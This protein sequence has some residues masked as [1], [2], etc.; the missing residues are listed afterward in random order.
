MRS[1]RGRLAAVAALVILLAAMI[2]LG[3]RP[4]GAL[5]CVGDCTGKGSVA[6]TDLVLGVNIA[7]GLVP[8][9]QCESFD[10]NADGMVSINELVIAVNNALTG[11]CVAP[12]AIVTATPSL[13]STTATP[14]PST[15]TTT[16]TPPST[17]T[18]TATSVPRFKD[19]G[20]GTITDPQTGLMWEKK[21]D[22][23][24][25]NLHDANSNYSWADVCSQATTVLCQPT[26][27]AAA[28]CSNG[29]EGGDHSGCATCGPGQGTCTPLKNPGALTTIWDWLDQLNAAGFAGHND[30]RLPTEAEL[31]SIVDFATATP[32]AVDQAFHGARCGP[33]CADA[34]SAAC[35]C[36]QSSDY[37]SASTY[38]IGEAWS[39]F[40]S[41]PVS[42]GTV[43]NLATINGMLTSSSASVRAV[44]AG[45]APMP[46]YLDNGDGTVTDQLTK[47]TWEKKVQLDLHPDPAN[48][49]DA[50]DTYV[51]A[52]VCTTNAT[53]FCQPTADASAACTADVGGN[54]PSCAQC[55][56]A[57]GSC[58]VT[59]TV[60]TWVAA[61][62]AASFAGHADWRVPTIHELQSILEYAHTQPAV[63]AV[64]H[65]SS[66]G[67][68]CTDVSNPACSCT[69]PAY[70]SASTYVLDRADAW[71][72]TFDYG[73]V[74]AKPTVGSSGV[75]A[76]RGS[77]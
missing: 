50:D 76:V 4:A 17:A 61:L 32:P 75:R 39:V 42:S 2:G 15:G 53:K 25:D 47:L 30:W 36:T 45:F 26:A 52:G 68:T 16:A 63:N 60:W 71:L 34:T 40:Y 74:T 12:T 18:P 58:N 5:S 6:I 77:S 49:H 48:L 43:A 66:C 46:R 7:L 10:A 38:K 23:G 27:D 19:N 59:D 57:D 3:A 14:N 1:L 56:E 69:G 24:V 22:A 67:A 62:N 55:A 41:G 11:L 65:G 72:A 9:T 28:A 29:A 37:W 70:W 13:P 8:V 20:D 44:R 73:Y 35:S 31:A 64:F 21:I 33:S 51:S 54:A